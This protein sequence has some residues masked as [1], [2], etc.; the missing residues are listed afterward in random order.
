VERPPLQKI[1][2]VHHYC[3]IPVRGTEGYGRNVAPLSNTELLYTMFKNR[4][5]LVILGGLFGPLGSTANFSRTKSDRSM[6]DTWLSL[7]D[8]VSKDVEHVSTP[9]LNVLLK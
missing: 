6:S 2:S 4:S 5:R 3:D 7:L 8:H 9:V 1:F